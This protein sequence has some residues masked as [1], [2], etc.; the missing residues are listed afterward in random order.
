MRVLFAD[1]LDVQRLTDQLSF[2]VVADV[3]LQR[4]AG[5][6]EGSRQRPRATQRDVARQVPQDGTQPGVAVA[7]HQQCRRQ[8][9]RSGHVDY[10]G[11]RLAGVPVVVEADLVDRVQLTG[12]NRPDVRLSGRQ[13]EADFLACQ[14]RTRIDERIALVNIVELEPVGGGLRCQAAVELLELRKGVAEQLVE[15]SG[16]RNGVRSLAT[17]VHMH[18]RGAVVIAVAGNQRTVVA[19]NDT[20]L[21]SVADQLEV[22]HVTDEELA[23][24]VQV[25]RSA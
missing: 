9:A 7:V 23:A 12:G 21:I 2:D 17:A 15:Q 19:A 16:R 6:E 11:C 22:G 24:V 5:R 20:T 8:R 10:Q 18:P 14:A 3:N 25:Q 13:L 1:V 4:I